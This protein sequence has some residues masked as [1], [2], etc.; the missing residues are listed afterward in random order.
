LDSRGNRGLP[1]S[2]RQ[3]GEV[4]TV[5]DIGT[6]GLAMLIVTLISLAACHWMEDEDEPF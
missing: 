6:L 5:I 3:A 2:N 4:Q 1:T